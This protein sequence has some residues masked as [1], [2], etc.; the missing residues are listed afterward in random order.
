MYKYLINISHGLQ[1]ARKAIFQQTCKNVYEK[2]QIKTYY[3]NIEESESLPVDWWSDYIEY[4]QVQTQEL[5]SFIRKNFDKNEIYIN[6]LDETLVPLTIQIKRDI[7]QAYTHEY[8]AFADKS[9]ERKLMQWESIIPYFNIYE[10]NTITDYSGEFPIVIKPN[11]WA[12]SR[13]VAILYNT[14]QLMQYQAN[15]KQISQKLQAKK[16]KTSQ[17]IIEEYIPGAMYTTTYF[18]DDTWAYIYDCFCEVHTL[19]HIGIQDFAILKRTITKE[20]KDTD[21]EFQINQIIE[22]TIDTYKIKNNFVFQDF[23]ENNEGK[24][25]SI[26]IN[27]R[28][29]GYRLQLYNLWLDR[30]IFEYVFWSNKEKEKK[31]IKTNVAA[32]SIFPTYD[33]TILVWFNEDILQKIQQLPSTKS[34]KKINA[35]I[36]QNVWHAKSWY[37]RLG[38]IILE[39]TNY[40]QFLQDCSY[41]EKVYK[42]ITMQ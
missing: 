12:Q 40:E 4:I 24:I 10:E 28:I 11:K 3:I 5:A 1:D 32:Y 42:N 13:G 25:K 30:N 20:T 37:N 21:K 22:K 41:V 19:Q 31:P 6:T 27:G 17:Y 18:V 2:Y 29:G 36:N 16:Y 35:Y 14:E 38:S 26:E 33:N 7:W 34:I 15:A 8:E 9:I 39:N 23:K